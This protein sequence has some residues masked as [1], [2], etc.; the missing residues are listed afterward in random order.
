MSRH[1]SV[2]GLKVPKFH[3]RSRTW[4]R[5]LDPQDRLR[6]GKDGKW[7]SSANPNCTANR[8]EDRFLK[9]SIILKNNIL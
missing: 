6:I 8:N 5:W 7:E 1:V 9:R 3:A 2:E 4:N